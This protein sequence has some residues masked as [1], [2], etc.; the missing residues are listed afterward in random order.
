VTVFDFVAP[1][2]VEVGVLNLLKKKKDVK[3][4]MQTTEV[5]KTCPKGVF[6]MENAILPYSEDCMH[7]E[8]RLNAEKKETIKL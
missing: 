8:S 1:G 2:S 7:Y 3:R 5:C 6:C 4:F